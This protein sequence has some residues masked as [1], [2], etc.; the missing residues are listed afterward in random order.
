[1]PY[2]GVEDKAMKYEMPEVRT[3]TPAISAIRSLVKSYLGT[4]DM[5]RTTPPKELIHAYEDWE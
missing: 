2:S 4:T 3:L 1:V 5:P